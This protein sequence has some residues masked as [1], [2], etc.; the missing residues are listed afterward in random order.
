MCVINANHP[1]Y[2]FYENNVAD[3][4]AYKLAGR[5]GKS[6]PTGKDIEGPFYRPNPPQGDELC[7]ADQPGERMIL[8]GKVT[9]TTG[10]P[11]Q[12]AR[13]DVW[14]ADKDGQYDV[15]DPDDNNNPNIPY[16]FRRWQETG[17]EGEYK[18]STI[19]PGHYQIGENRWRTGHIHVKVSAEGYRP[20]TT[21]LYFQDDKY[22]ATNQWFSPERV[23]KEAIQPDGWISAKFNLVLPKVES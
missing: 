11:I 3:T 23:V 7:P 21:Q 4:S 9:D 13:V 8:S 18:F 17:N 22:N 10:S 15:A 1:K 5:Q 19:R 16:K 12:G 14:Q 6:A 2:K 20:L